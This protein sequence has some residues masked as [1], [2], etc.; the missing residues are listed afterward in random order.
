VDADEL[1]EQGLR[2]TGLQRQILGV[3]SRSATLRRSAILPGVTLMFKR[4]LL[5]ISVQPVMQRI[6][7][8]DDC[9]SVT[10]GYCSGSC[11]NCTATCRGA[12]STKMLFGERGGDVELSVKEIL[13]VLSAKEISGKIKTT[14]RG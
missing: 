12:A 9:G 5:T 8:D 3:F 7:S 2:K 10:C 14:R 11:T 6:T 1:I 4:R 13:Q